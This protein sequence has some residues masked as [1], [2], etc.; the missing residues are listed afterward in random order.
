MELSLPINNKKLPLI[1]VVFNVLFFSITSYAQTSTQRI[2]ATNAEASADEYSILGILS[3]SV[4]NANAATDSDLTTFATLNSIVVN[5][6]GGLISVGGEASIKLNFAETLQA[7][8][9]VTIKLGLGG[10]VL[11]ALDT[12]S[13]ESNAGEEII[14]GDL[15]GALTGNQQLEVIITPDEDF[16]G[17]KISLGVPEGLLNVGVLTTVDVYEAFYEESSVG[18]GCIDPVDALVLIL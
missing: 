16:N 6:L 11:S 8:T 9:P 1:L 15:V 3:G 12:D 17:V 13:G 18:S 2:Y 4:D 10:D 5:A 14:L 7:N